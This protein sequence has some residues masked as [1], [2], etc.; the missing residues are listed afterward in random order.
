RAKLAERAKRK[1]ML[2]EEPQRDVLQFLFEHAPLENWERDVLAIVREEAYYFAPQAMTKIMNEGWACLHGDS[3]VFT[4]E[5]LVPIADVVEGRAAAVSDGAQERAVYDRH[6][7]RDHETVTL[8]TRRG[9]TVCGS[10]THRVLRSD[11]RTWT[12]LDELR[13]GDRL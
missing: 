7:I 10:I 3:L 6:A 12:R 8:R 13:P 4:P 11:G 2:P 5:G 9:L 1:R